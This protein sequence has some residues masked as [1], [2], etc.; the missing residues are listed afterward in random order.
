MIRARRRAFIALAFATVVAIAASAHAVPP[1]SKGS[2]VPVV[3]AWDRD[4]DLRRHLGMPILV[5]YED[6]DS[7]TMNQAVKDDLAKLAA[8]G[9]YKNA[10]AVFAVADVE[11]YDY[12]PVRGIVKDAIRQESRKQKTTIYCDWN[13]SVRKSLGLTRGTSNVALFGKDGGVRF[14]HAGQMQEAR[15]KEL[16]RLL[17]AEVDR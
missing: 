2:S 7:A 10:F 17:R 14:F 15:R 13:G 5:V 4:N 11:G 8:V 6:K 9:G 1:L 16:I 3:D 12:W